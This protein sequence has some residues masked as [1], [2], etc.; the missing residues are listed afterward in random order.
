MNDNEIE[1]YIDKIYKENDYLIF[2]YYIQKY[3]EK[4]IL[5]K[6]NIVGEG[7]KKIISILSDN[8]M[9]LNSYK[10]KMMLSLL[11][12]FGIN[13]LF[14]IPEYKSISIKS[15]K[16]HI[17]NQLIDYFQI[18]INNDNNKISI[19]EQSNL[20]LLLSL[21]SILISSVR[22]DYQ[23]NIISDSSKQSN[24]N[25][26]EI[27]VNNLHLK[28]DKDGIIYSLLKELPLKLNNQFEE[29]YCLLID[30]L[31]KCSLPNI[32]HK[33]LIKYSYNVLILYY[34]I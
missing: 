16:K 2:A 27:P 15:N 20:K 28:Y 3:G 31:S 22:K 8:T 5:F 13:I 11:N 6:S 23:E 19:Y 26:D 7:I 18:L 1:T 12:I 32:P 24:N 9:Q 14:D 30:C 17:M 25:K 21:Y 34:S 10:I 33:S 29:Y 4:N